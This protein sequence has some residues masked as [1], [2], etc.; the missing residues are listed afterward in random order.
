[1]SEFNQNGNYNITF[2]SSTGAKTCFG[3]IP[4]RH[5]NEFYDVAN[6]VE[7]SINNSISVCTDGT[8]NNVEGEGSCLGDM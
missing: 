7:V 1:M 8:T 6:D 3:Y 5:V 4:K 2:A